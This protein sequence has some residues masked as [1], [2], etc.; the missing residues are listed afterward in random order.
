MVDV[1]NEKTE[2]KK[3]SLRLTKMAGFLAG[4][5]DSRVAHM[6]QRGG[7]YEEGVVLTR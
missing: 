4:C 5:E 6:R 3:S 2:T 1:E 7:A